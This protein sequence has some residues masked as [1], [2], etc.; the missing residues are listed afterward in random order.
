MD[1]INEYDMKIYENIRCNRLNLY[2]YYK[3]IFKLNFTNI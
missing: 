2:E 1:L 3:Q